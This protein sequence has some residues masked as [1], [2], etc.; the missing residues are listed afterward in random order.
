MAR[1][2][3]TRFLGITVA[4]VAGV[5]VVGYFAQKA[6]VTERPQTYIETGKRL[7]RERQWKD[8]AGNFAKAGKLD[9]T[10]ASTQVLL[11]DAMEQLRETDPKAGR[12]QF[13]ALQ[14]ALEIDPKHMPAL[15]RMLALAQQNAFSPGAVREAAFSADFASD[16]ARRILEQEPENLDV[17]ALQDLLPMQLWLRGVEMDDDKVKGHS[18]SLD[19]LVE[20]RPDNSDLLAI[21]AQVHLRRASELALSGRD[22]PGSIAESLAAARM[23]ETATVGSDK[24]LMEK[25]ASPAATT[26]PAIG[27]EARSKVA[28][29]YSRASEIYSRLEQFATSMKDKDR[30]T[31]YAAKADAAVE[32]AEA[33]VAPNDPQFTQIRIQSANVRAQRGD[34]EQ[35]ETKLRDLIAQMSQEPNARMALVRLLSRKPEKLDE[36]VKILVGTSEIIATTP[37]YRGMEYDVRYLTAQ[38]RLQQ[39]ARAKPSPEREQLVKDIKAD[40]AEVED[41]A[42]DAG[43]ALTPAVLSLRGR[44]ELTFGQNVDAIQTLNRARVL[45]DQRPGGADAT[46]LLLLAQAYQQTQQTGQARQFMQEAIDKNP[47]FIGARVMLAELL[48]RTNE[49]EAARAEVKKIEQKAPDAP[50]LAQLRMRMLD[51]K[52][53][54]KQ[55][56]D[57]YAKLPEDDRAQR[58]NKAQAALGLGRRE[59]AQRLLGLIL[60]ADPSDADAAEISAKIYLA[61]GDRDSAL[62]V[63]KTALEKSPDKM[64]LRILADA[65]RGATPAEISATRRELILKNPDEFSREMQ[66]FDLERDAGRADEALKHVKRATELKSDDG[67]A[68]AALF[69]TYLARRNFDEAEKLLDPLAKLNADQ[70]NGILYSIKLEQVRGNLT[71]AKELGRELT[72]QLPEFALSYFTLGQVLQQAGEYEDAVAKYALTLEKQPDNLEAVRATVRC[73]YALNRPEEAKRFIDLGL[74]NQPKDAGLRDMLI[75]HYLNNRQPEKAIPLM[76]EDAQRNPSDAG[77]IKGLGIA[78]FRAARERALA[79]DGE[80]TKKFARLAVDTLTTAVATWPD[81]REFYAYLADVQLNTNDAVGGEKT[82]KSLAARPAWKDKSEPLKMLAEFYAKG[83][84]F[85]DAE[86]VMREAMKVSQ[87]A[88]DVQLPLAS[89]LASRGKPVDAIAVLDLA[90][91]GDPRVVRTRIETQINSGKSDEAEKSLDVAMAPDAFAKLTTAD[92]VELLGLSGLN[93]MNQAKFDVALTR[94][95]NAVGL[96]DKSGRALFWRGLCRLRQTKPDVAGALVDLQMARDLSPENVD[97]HLALVDAYALSNDSVSAMSELETVVSIAPLNKVARLR[98]INAYSTMRPPKWRSVEQLL[99]EARQQPQFAKDADWPDAESN[100]WL[101]RGDY[102][103]AMTANQAAQQL[104]P[105]NPKIAN[106]YLQILLASRNFAVLIRETDKLLKDSGD[107]WWLRVA[108]A[109]AKRGLEDKPGAMDELIAALSAADAKKDEEAQTRVVQAIA[110]LVGVDEAIK[111]ITPRSKTDSKWLIPLAVLQQARGDATAARAA[112]DDI[113]ARLNDYEPARRAAALRTAGMI[114]LTAKPAALVSQAADAYDKLLLIQPDDL[115]ALNNMACLWVE[116]ASPPQPQKALVYSQR[117]YDLLEKR[118]GFEALIFDTHGWVL[119]KVGRVDEAIDLLRQVV[120][121]S[122]FLEA[123][124]HLAEAY[125]TKAFPEEAQK[126]LAGAQELIDQATRAKQPIDAKLKSAVDDALARTQKALT[127]KAQTKLP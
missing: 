51:V 102:D 50:E 53:D 83:S 106:T 47:D 40:L 56:D 29:I 75:K 113:M 70:A 62:R 66:L 28:L 110:Q 63:L 86:A 16:I 68:L 35:A 109:Q 41:K 73:Y 55:V 30:A 46:L 20:Q 38:L 85:D 96:S 112:A 3:N 25:S 126:Q 79:G 31:G 18:A 119:L 61:A 84:R 111:Q 117:A 1:R 17:Q 100:M 44:M 22:R 89:F 59:E 7:L 43:D 19:A 94:L 49:I 78:Y 74:K 52:K 108:R 80:G 60:T 65:A 98:L 88:I 71:R 11:A 87:N 23:V 45:A 64:S 58:L 76:Q 42:A 114:Y 127:D 39:Y 81:D 67:Q 95:N 107:V 21:A 13:A 54:A 9:S 92:Q 99:V 125:L 33:L 105:G 104:A 122:P 103:K 82:L 123:H 90:N 69:Q 116:T 120:E 4:S 5:V 101:A 27:A 72:R 115:T 6:L 2:I 8:A 15:K 14:R 24:M 26:N 124:Y 91:T 77:T 97:V 12:G 34:F 36:A 37:R 93:A 118:G 48:I 32:R 10:D 121:R 57:L